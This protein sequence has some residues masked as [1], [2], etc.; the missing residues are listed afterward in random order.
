MNDPAVLEEL[1]TV[2]DRLAA[3][4]VNEKARFQLL[5]KALELRDKFK[6]TFEAGDLVRSFLSPTS[7][8]LTHRVVSKQKRSDVVEVTHEGRKSSNLL[9]TG[10]L[11]PAR[12]ETT[13]HVVKSLDAIVQQE[14]PVERSRQGAL[15]LRL[16]GAPLLF[17][18]LSS[19]RRLS[20]QR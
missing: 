4:N 10:W 2:I 12:P 9:S 7:A 19:P 5:D 14:E 16:G 11:V 1:H 8:K 18:L 13:Q 15:S 6:F 3:L 17:R 20:P